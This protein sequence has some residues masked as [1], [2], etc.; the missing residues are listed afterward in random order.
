M[1]RPDRKEDEVRR[2]LETRHPPVPADLA[3]R[4]TEH[5]SRLLRR[6]RALRRAAWTL[7]VVAAIAF[8]V[9]ASMAEPWLTPP[10][11]TTPP[12]EGW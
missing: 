1:N 10:S 3:A 12:L 11:E 6:H 8:A 5:G 4:A 9:W 7:L 2:M